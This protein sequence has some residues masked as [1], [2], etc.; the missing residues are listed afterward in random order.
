MAQTGTKNQESREAAT[1]ADDDLP[2]ASGAGAAAIAT[3]LREAI[4]GGRY[5]NGERLPAERELTEHFGVARGT[6]REALRR[7]EEM[8][9]VT[10]RMGSGTFVNHRAGPGED[11]IAELT[12]PIE[13]IDVRLAIEPDIARMAVANATARDLERLEAALIECE[14]AGGDREAF[15]QADERFH[16]A[17]AE[18]TRNPLMIWLY[19]KINDVRGHTQWNA[20]KGKI[21]TDARIGEYNTQ[22]RKLFEAVR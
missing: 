15:S 9:L 7:L 3:R 1:L 6:V 11:D 19:G 17:L 14:A 16:R 18:A 13:L 8:G 5:A 21:L 10:R 4:L 20:M 12:S 2:A 22:H